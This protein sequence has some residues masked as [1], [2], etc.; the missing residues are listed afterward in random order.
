M[1]QANYPWRCKKKKSLS[2]NIY[3][4]KIYSLHVLLISV[5]LHRL[6]NCVWSA[7]CQKNILLILRSFI[8][9]KLVK[10][11]TSTLLIV[12]CHNSK[13]IWHVDKL[14]YQLRLN[15]KTEACAKYCAVWEG[16]IFNRDYSS[17]SNR[18]RHRH[19]YL[20][21]ITQKGW[22]HITGGSSLH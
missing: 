16:Y 5:W 15:H 4:F 14:C 19:V 22:W 8:Q 7:A 11:Q 9:N 18:A 20:L 13:P 3:I 1:L 17:L 10:N 6:Q 21:W 12:W 2:V